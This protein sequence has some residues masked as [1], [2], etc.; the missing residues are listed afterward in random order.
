MGSSTDSSAAAVLRFPPLRTLGSVFPSRAA[1]NKSRCNT[2]AL[3]MAGKQPSSRVT[4]EVLGLEVQVAQL[5]DV[6]DVHV[7]LVD[8][9]FVEILGFSR[10]ERIIV[11]W[12]STMNKELN[13][14]KTELLK[15]RNHR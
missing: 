5:V 11:V 1:I 14:N 12:E 7:L 4:C 8:L 9:G 6:A 2:S 3:Q 10:R 13:N 15:H